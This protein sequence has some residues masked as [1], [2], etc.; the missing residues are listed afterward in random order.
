MGND[1]LA[2]AGNQYVKWKDNVKLI[3]TVFSLAVAISLGAIHLH[4]QA[5]H[6]DAVNKRE[7]DR[8]TLSVDNGFARI[9]DK[10]D[11]LVENL[12]KEK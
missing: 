3:I 11:R 6:K 1:V 5:P 9:N 8:L 4:S 10:L 7:F 2:E 12:P